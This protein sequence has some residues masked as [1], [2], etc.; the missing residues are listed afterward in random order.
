[1]IRD[2][3]HAAAGSGRMV[4][5]WRGESRPVV[6]FIIRNVGA[7]CSSNWNLSSRRNRLVLIAQQHSRTCPGLQFARTSALEFHPRYL[8]AWFSCDFSQLFTTCCQVCALFHLF[9][10]CRNGWQ[11]G[12]FGRE[13]VSESYAMSAIPVGPLGDVVSGRNRR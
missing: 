12:R 10:F 8:S 1:M 11:S 6:L 13:I 5:G 3:A 7:K 4:S 9:L 2:H